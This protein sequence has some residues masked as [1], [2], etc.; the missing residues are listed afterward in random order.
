MRKKLC[1]ATIILG[2]LMGI[3][4]IAD[5]MLWTEPETGFASVGPFW[6]RYLLMIPVGAGALATAYCVSD[7]KRLPYRKKASRLTL[8][9]LA[10]CSTFYGV[11]TSFAVYFGYRDPSSSHH[12]TKMRV[13]FDLVSKFLCSGLF[14][15]F[16]VWCVCFLLQK[17][18]NV[19]NWMLYLGVA[20]GAGFYLN[21][22]VTF[23]T[24][25]AS[26]QR[27]YITIEIF[28]ALFAV[29]LVAAYQ[30]SIYVFSYK[31]G[32]RSICRNGLLS[33]FFGTCLA[34][35]QE[36]WFFSTGESSLVK[37]FLTIILGMVG[38]FGAINAMSIVK[39]K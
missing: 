36:I 14:I 5:L 20:G 25:A 29:M 16:G 2:I 38:V 17:K 4:R 31:G 28:A 9:A 23:L 37:L 13:I 26:L 21:A 30:R 39:Q 12:Q 34:L 22:M 6:L 19:G 10:F 11:F 7:K 27:I 8:W 18:R 24:Q 35:P 1:M 3:L 32:T 15:L 33:F